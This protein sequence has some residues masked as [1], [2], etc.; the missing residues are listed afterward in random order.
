MNEPES[1]PDTESA[2]VDKGESLEGKHAAP[3]SEPEHEG[4]VGEVVEHVEKYWPGHRR[5][6]QL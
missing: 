5:R 3:E 6:K 2:V 1:T 4:L